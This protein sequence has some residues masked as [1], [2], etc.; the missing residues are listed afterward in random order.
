MPFI[1][2]D[3]LIFEVHAGIFAV[4]DCIVG[5]RIHSSDARKRPRCSHDE[6]RGCLCGQGS[7]GTWLN[8]NEIGQIFPVHDHSRKWFNH[9]PTTQEF[10]WNWGDYLRLLGWEEFLLDFAQHLG[11][12]LETLHFMVADL[13][14]HHPANTLTVQNGR[15][16]N[17]DVFLTVFAIEQGRH[18]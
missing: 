10:T 2:H 16:A 12:V 9:Y 17:V 6:W 1:K 4:S 5:Y 14:L 13:Q 7:T 3:G 18:R 15:G 11:G 8:Q